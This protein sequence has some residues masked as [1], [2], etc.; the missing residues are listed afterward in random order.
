[1][2]NIT[3]YEKSTCTKCKQLKKVL[4]EKGVTYK[5]VNYFI[6]PIT[7]TK[8]KQLLKK[9]NLSAKDIIRR[10]EETY[11]VVKKEYGGKLSEDQ[12]IECMI[13]YPELIQRPIVEMGDKAVLARP[14]ENIEKLF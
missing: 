8:L 10:N 2:V 1:M 11:K 7:K 4:E 12:L 13:E 9:M 3:V 6:T 14:T 5:E